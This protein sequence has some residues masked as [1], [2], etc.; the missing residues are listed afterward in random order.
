MPKKQTRR[1]KEPPSDVWKHV[2]EHHDHI[3]DLYNPDK[4]KHDAIMREH[5]EEYS[6][7]HSHNV[8]HVPVFK[9]HAG[10]RHHQHDLKVAVKALKKEKAASVSASAG[11]ASANASNDNP[12]IQVNVTRRS[13]QQQEKVVSPVAATASASVPNSNNSPRNLTVPVEFRLSKGAQR[14]PRAVVEENPAV[15]AAKARLAASKYVPRNIARSALHTTTEPAQAYIPAH[16]HKAAHEQVSNFTC[17]QVLNEQLLRMMTLLLKAGLA[18]TSHDP[19]AVGTQLRARAAELVEKEMETILHALVKVQ[20]P[21]GSHKNHALSQLCIKLTNELQREIFTDERAIQRQ[22]ALAASIRSEETNRAHEEISKAVAAKDQELAQ[23]KQDF[24]S[25]T[26]DLHTV[27]R[28]NDV[29]ETELERLSQIQERFNQSAVELRLQGLNYKARVHNHSARV[30]HSISSRM[31]FVPDVIAKEINILKG[32][33]APGD[34]T[35]D[36]VLDKAFTKKSL[37]DVRNLIG[38]IPAVITDTDE[39]GDIYIEPLSGRRMH[40][41]GTPVGVQTQKQIQVR[42]DVRRMAGVS[43]ARP[44]HVHT[45]ERLALQNSNAETEVKP[46]NISSSIIPNAAAAVNATEPTGRMRSPQMDRDSKL[47]DIGGSHDLNIVNSLHS[48]AEAKSSPT[49][50]NRAQEHERDSR[51]AQAQAKSSQSGYDIAYREYT[52]AKESPKDRASLSLGTG[53]GSGGRY[54]EGRTR[55]ARTNDEWVRW[56][57]AEEV[58]LPKSFPSRTAGSLIVEDLED[59]N[60]D[61]DEEE[62]EEEEE[63]EGEEDGDSEDDSD[64]SPSSSDSEDDDED[65]YDE[66]AEGDYFVTSQVQNK[67]PALGRGARNAKSHELDSTS[68]TSEDTYI[69]GKGYAYPAGSFQEP[70]LQGNGVGVGNGHV[71]NNIFGMA[72]IYPGASIRVSRSGNVES[73]AAADTASDNNDNDDDDDDDEQ[74]SDEMFAKKRAAAH[75]MDDVRRFIQQIRQSR[76]IDDADVSLLNEAMKELDAGDQNTSSQYSG[77]RNNQGVGRSKK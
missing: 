22:K 47:S 50:Y 72:N 71:A 56:A 15:T 74:D 6:P 49:A 31:G 75:D 35:Y 66:N 51:E 69:A 39:H 44:S 20:G 41:D 60:D 37:R 61:D 28:R 5:K 14:K 23:L 53:A 59:D 17:E 52:M 73:T 3:S 77:S 58:P 13:K 16:P 46:N 34:P 10:A 19:V 36:E 63:E 65:E 76:G 7:Q 11:G 30:L 4:K 32:L 67:N 48:R 70:N 21:S 26:F 1:H 33:K 8:S 40:T 25:T 45:H 54:I 64:Y 18:K 38:A 43:P 24:K 62:E 27:S 12:I 57:V 2:L 9:S 55:S 42:H 68:L 29:L